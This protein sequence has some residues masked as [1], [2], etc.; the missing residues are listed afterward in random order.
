[1]DGNRRWAKNHGVAKFEGHRVGAQRLKEAVRFL[2]DRGV[3]HTVLYA[4]S[5]ENWNR[6]SKEVAYLLDLFVVLLEKDVAE[7]GAE[8]FCIRFA[9]Q[10][11]RFSPKTQE[12]MRMAEEE[13]SSNTAATI[14]ICVS[15]GGRAEII[16]AA[17]AAAEAGPITEES[18]SR[19]L[20]TS[21]MP[22]PDVIIRTGGE[23]RLSGFLTWQSVYSELF[24][25]DTLWPDFSNEELGAILVE[26]ASR[27]RRH[28]K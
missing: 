10:R 11:E 9:G 27:E 25:S 7:L 14:W 22:D 8:G 17:R 3:R 21:G 16:S 2:R 19:N 15:Y 5:T 18:L 1:M 12:L 4:F 28:G 13:T 26:F 23:K 20:W 6:D 24:Y